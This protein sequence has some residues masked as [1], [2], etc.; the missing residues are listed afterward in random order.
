MQE[1]LSGIDEE[2]KI[3]GAEG[4]VAVVEAMFTVVISTCEE[5]NEEHT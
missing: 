4:E 5:D 3:I 1:R 2:G